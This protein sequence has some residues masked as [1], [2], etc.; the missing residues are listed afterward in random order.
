MVDTP[1]L[2]VLVSR[3]ALTLAVAAVALCA[4]AAPASAGTQTLSLA[5]GYGD[6]YGEAAAEGR[7]TW[8]VQVF[9]DPAGSWR[10]F[11][12]HQ[13][14]RRDSASG[15]YTITTRQSP[16]RTGQLLPAAAVSVSS[17]EH[18]VTVQAVQVPIDKVVHASTTTGASTS[19]TRGSTVLR[20]TFRLAGGSSQ[21]HVGSATFT[22]RSGC[23]AADHYEDTTRH[24]EAA[25]HVLGADLVVEREG[26]DDERTAD[27]TI[28]SYRLRGTG[29]C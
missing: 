17:N 24:A 12:L 28:S 4:F 10:A 9:Q 13:V 5:A 18:V 27:A 15:A 25:V 3:P 23:A 26:A 7:T 14:V 8:D 29:S 11:V 16:G 6:R 21:D 19:V 20:G 22:P 2:E 1:V